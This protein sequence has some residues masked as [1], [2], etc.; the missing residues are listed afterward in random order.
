MIE[1]QLFVTCRMRCSYCFATDVP[2]YHNF[3]RTCST[4][5]HESQCEYIF[6]HHTSCAHCY[7]TYDHNP[8]HI[9]NSNCPHCSYVAPCI[10]ML[11]MHLTSHEAVVEVSQE[12]TEARPQTSNAASY[13]EREQTG[14]KRRREASPEPIGRF[15][16]R[17]VTRGFRYLQRF[18]K[19]NYRP[20]PGGVPDFF[21]MLDELQPVV[22]KEVDQYY[23]QHGALTFAFSVNVTFERVNGEEFA[24]TFR[25]EL[26]Q[27]LHPH[28][29]GESFNRGREMLCAEFDTFLERGSGS[30]LNSINTVNIECYRYAPMGGGS[31]IATPAKYRHKRAIVNVINKDD[32]LC[33]LYATLAKQHPVDKNK[34]RRG[35]YIP[36]LSTLKTE[37]LTFPLPLHQM[38]KYEEMNNITVNVYMVEEDGDMIRPVYLS[39][40]VQD[41]PY[42]F[43]LIVSKDD[44]TKWHYTWISSL[45]RLLRKDGADA[46][47]FCTFCL[48]GYNIRW[49]GRRNLEEHRKHCDGLKKCVKVTYPPRKKQIVKFSRYSAMQKSPLVL[50]CDFESCNKEVNLKKGESTLDSEQVVTGFCITPVTIPELPDMDPV[51]YTGDDA[52]QRYYE[53]VKKFSLYMD[54]LYEE[55]GR[56][57]MEKIEGT[58][59]ETQHENEK[60]C[61][62][63]ERE[64]RCQLSLNKFMEIAKQRKEE[65]KAKEID[66]DYGEDVDEKAPDEDDELFMLGPRIRDHCHWSGR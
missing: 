64:F 3:S 7:Q 36:H 13:S 37:G 50:Y 17:K 55:K 38:K 48:R 58:P 18:I 49:N 53:E 62:I 24:H 4:C 14:G 15:T 10:N 63:C 28:T 25:S 29:F 65:D 66:E 56:Q 26:E 57:P 5:Q 27:H 59:L 44:P 33:A 52:L 9:S 1:P 54:E 40:R 60:H 43:L 16:R 22:R 19:F 20:G 47:T 51:E 46:K 2:Y 12:V 6:N 61:W 39:K 21:R 30:R 11:E 34:E 31:W 32:N 35:N 8:N 23:N 45:D 42:N 41:D